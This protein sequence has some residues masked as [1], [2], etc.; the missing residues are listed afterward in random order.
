MRGWG[1]RQAPLTLSRRRRRRIEGRTA[2]RACEAAPS[3]RYL[4]RS[5][6]EET[7]NGRNERFSRQRQR[8]RRA[9]RSGLAERRDAGAGLGLYRR[10]DL[11]A[12]A[13]A[14]LLRPALE[15]R[16]P[17]MRGAEAGRLYPLLCRRGAGRRHPRH[18]RRLPRLREPLRPP[19]RRVLPRVPRQH[20]AL[21]LPLPQ[22]DLRPR[23]R[24]GG[25]PVPP[26]RQGQGRHAGG[27]RHGGA[28]A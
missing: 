24:P 15:L 11:R 10:A 9:R 18:G 19:G 4:P 16:R 2:P 14:H 22:L 26:R 21:R 12:R 23:R 7:R 20:R 25:G 8:R 5:G 3:V 1:T 17:R 6:E 28:R 13:G 27:L